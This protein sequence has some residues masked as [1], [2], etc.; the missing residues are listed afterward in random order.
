MERMHEP[1]RKTDPELEEVLAELMAREPIFHREEWGTTRDDFEKM[2]E[3]EFWEVG[4]SGRRYSREAVL[5]ELERR[6]AAGYEDVWATSDF[7][8]QRLADEVYL[9]TYT[10][11]QDEVR[12]TRRSTIW[13]RTSEGWKIVFHQG[14]MVENPANI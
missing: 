7:F 10:L 1:T 11:L 3:V 5:D 8:C 4:A 12:L 2:M 9:L 13:Q 6:N 14:T